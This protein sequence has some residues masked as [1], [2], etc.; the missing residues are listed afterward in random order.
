M[1]KNRN[2]CLTGSL[3]LCL[4]LLHVGASANDDEQHYSMDD[5]YRV[6]K[7]DTHMHLHST[8]PT[9]MLEAQRDKFRVLSINVDN[10]SRPSID[11]QQRI[12]EILLKKY[13]DTFAFAATF[14][15]NNY[16][17][18]GWQESVI[19]RIATAVSHGAVA[20]KVWKNIGMSLRADNGAM[21]MIDDPH[22]KPVFDYLEKI[23]LPVLGHQGEPKNCWLPLAQM[24]VIGDREYF[25]AHPQYYMYLHPDMPGYEDQLHARDNMLAQHRNLQFAALHL[26]SLEWSVDELSQFLERYP[27][28]VV[29]L[30]ARISHLQSQAIQNPDKV[31]NFL[32]KYQDRI[33]YGTDSEQDADEKTAANFSKETLETWQQDWRYFNTT[34]TMHV[35]DLDQPVKGLALPKIVVDKI[36]HRNAE[37]FFPTAW[38]RGKSTEI[39]MRL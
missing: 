7:I 27:N 2:K 23:H 9:F 16:D 3:L 24:T 6:P 39:G 36:Y 30:A 29:D 17:Q 37:R 14:S 20:V 32:I 33:M 22:F 8:Q 35:P 25:E 31:R 19:K 38:G 1:T 34:E 15:V 4:S 10:P 21:V 28:V 13:P 26:A 11:E 12:S 18:P 5:F